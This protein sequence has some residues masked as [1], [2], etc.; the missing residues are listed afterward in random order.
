MVARRRD[1]DKG[2]RTISIE[3]CRKDADIWDR[4]RGRIKDEVNTAANEKR[5]EAA[6]AGNVG[7]AAAKKAEFSAGDLGSRD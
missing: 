5:R 7:R 4:K 3:L 6:Q 1:I 2:Q